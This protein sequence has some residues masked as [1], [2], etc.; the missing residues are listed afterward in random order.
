MESENYYMA[1][2]LLAISAEISLRY[3]RAASKPPSCQAM[4]SSEDRKFPGE[5]CH[6]LH[7]RDLAQ[8]KR[9]RSDGLLGEMESP[10][11]PDWIRNSGDTYPE[12][13]NSQLQNGG[14]FGFWVIWFA[15]RLSGS[16][17]RGR[18]NVGSALCLA[19]G[20]VCGPCAA[21]MKT[22]EWNRPRNRS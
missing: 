16:S 15:P 13:A 19:L 10:R 9:E 14:V 1:R 18:A 11:V 2:E 4:L 21:V 6:E 3:Y 22:L 7:V 12:A 17:S 20:R 5:S 8:T